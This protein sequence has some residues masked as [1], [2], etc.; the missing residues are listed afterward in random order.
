MSAR[1]PRGTQ[2]DKQEPPPWAVIRS[3]GLARRAGGARA[4][5]ALAHRPRTKSKIAR[6]VP[7]KSAEITVRSSPGSSSL[8][9]RRDNARLPPC[10]PGGVSLAADDRRVDRGPINPPKPDRRQGKNGHLRRSLGCG[11]LLQAATTRH[12]TRK[13]LPPSPGLL[14]LRQLSRAFV[15]VLGPD[16]G[17]APPRGQAPDQRAALRPTLALGGHHRGETVPRAISAPTRGT[18][19]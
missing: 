18:Q 10:D 2:V 8:D 15:L 12:M 4:L 13:G 1:V 19:R 14:A 6:T 16:P 11:L 5:Q 7:C 17:R 9:G 3:G